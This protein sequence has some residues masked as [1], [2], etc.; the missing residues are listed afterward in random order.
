MDLK[1]AFEYAKNNDIIFEDIDAIPR[2]MIIPKES[3][4]VTNYGSYFC[5]RYKD[6]VIL[7]IEPQLSKNCLPSLVE[8][9]K[10]C[11]LNIKNMKKQEI[12]N[13]LQNYI[14]FL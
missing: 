10:I 14:E 8:L 13:Q 5:Y 12:I 6:T 9:S 7:D 1:S 2:K 11:K 3:Q 4:Y